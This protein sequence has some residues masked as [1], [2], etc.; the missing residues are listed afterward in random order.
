MPTARL[1]FARIVTLYAL[2]LFGFLTYLYVVEPT[3][4]IAK[5]GIEASG[6]P[7]SINFLRAGPG[8][9]FGGMLIAAVVGLMR[10][11]WLIG[12]LAVLVLFTG[13]VVAVRLY[14]MAIDGTT[15]IQL[16]ELR[17]EGIS[18]LFFVA[19]LVLHPRRSAPAAS[20]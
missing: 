8:A 18:W 10:P 9:L 3:D 2:L 12:G 4:H 20:P 5:F 6:A 17:N 15:P 1:W 19:A 7:E 11:A 14:G 13:C 16:S